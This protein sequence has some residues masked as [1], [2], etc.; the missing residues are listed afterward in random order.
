MKLPKSF[1]KHCLALILSLS[2]SFEGLALSVGQ[3][4]VTRST[5]PFFMLDS[6]KPNVDGPR[7]AHVGIKIR[8]TSGGQLNQVYVKLT[9]LTKTGTASASLG[10]IGTS[11]SIQWIGKMNSTDTGI[12]YFYI[13]F[14]GNTAF[15]DTVKLTVQVY[16]SVSGTVS[17]QTS[18]ILRSSISSNAGGLLVAKTISTLRHIGT[19]VTDTVTYSY[20][21]VQ[22]G[23]E[24]TLYPCGDTTFK[25]GSFQLINALVLSSA[26]ASVTAGTRNTLYFVATATTGGSG[27][28]I[29]MVYYYINKMVSGDSTITAPYA[30][31]T[32]GNTNFKY[33]SNFRAAG[34]FSYFLSATGSLSVTK[35]V[36]SIHNYPG[37]TVTY[38]V[39]VTNNNGGAVT[40]DYFQDTLPTGYTYVALESTSDITSAISSELPSAGNSGAISFRGG[41]P[42]TFPYVSYTVNASSTVSLKYKVK[43]KNTASL[44]SDRNVA[45]IFLGTTSGGSD[46][47][48]AYVH[49]HVSGTLF[50]DTNGLTDALVNGTARDSAGSSLVYAYLVNGSNQVMQRR[51][52]NNGNGTFTFDSVPAQTNYTVRLSNTAATINQT[53]PSTANLPS[54]YVAIGEDYGSANGAGSGNESGTP[55]ASIA[56]NV[57]TAHLTTIQFGIQQAPTP[58]DTT[59]SSQL[60]PGGTNAITIATSNF[61]GSDP[62]GRLI[63]YKF[64]G[65][66]SNTTTFSINGTSYTSGTFPGAG[67]TVSSISSVTLDPVDGAL[68]AVIP[69][70]V[71]DNAGQSGLSTANVNVPLQLLSVSGTLFND[72]NGLVDATVS[73]TAIDQASS[74]TIYAYL[75]NG[76]GDVVAKDTLNSGNGT[77]TFSNAA[78]GST[79]YTVRMSTSNV[80]VG[81][82]AP[83]SASLPNGWVAVGDSYGSS[84]IAGSGNDSSA[85]GQIEVT[86]GTANVTGVNFG[87]E[88]SNTSY[89]KTYTNQNPNTIYSNSGNG[90]YPK[91]LALNNASGTS[92]TTVNASSA[93]ILP[94]KVSASDP[95][96]GNYGGSSGSN[97]VRTF[98]LTSLPDAS[99]DVL[100]YFNGSETILLIEDPTDT[101]SSWAYWDETNEQYRIPSF[102][103]SELYVYS[104]NNGHASFSFHYGYLDLAG[105]LGTTG[106]YSVVGFGPLSLQ[107]MSF[108]S[109]TKGNKTTLKWTTT[110][111]LGLDRYVLEK[112]MDLVGWTNVNEQQALNKGSITNIYTFDDIISDGNNYYRLRSMEEN[113][114]S[115]LSKI[116][117]VVGSHAV[118]ISVYPV[119]AITTLN[120]LVGETSTARVYDATGKM[121]LNAGLVFKGKPNSLNV[122]QLPAGFYSLEL[123][124]TGT[125][126]IHPIEVGYK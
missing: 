11:D 64:T 107:L 44:A 27:N 89:D 66:P 92:N 52:L 8:N 35:S 108:E 80:N 49:V 95:E 84:N 126:S 10:Y 21:N 119:P 104:I 53:A 36:S 14:P 90:T 57:G 12:A 48:L 122:E 28:Q 31:L 45:H 38:T 97:S 50:R 71:I 110:N 76:S 4:A 86:T 123:T 87:I 91:K 118:A 37:D 55:D 101:D 26:V 20:G 15:N 16:D 47:A 13:K 9:A 109:K 17:F 41:L 61:T 112:S 59:L 5:A 56:A 19:L 103:A 114:T 29:K 2:L 40:F 111:E 58:T 120:I 33:S 32:S 85:N 99:N 1:I 105:L 83:S 106:I 69:F 25:A 115:E 96:D 68:T 100:V 30:G 78:Y 62:D 3:V 75:V 43:L 23:D 116:I 54:T 82:S 63:Q 18:M 22:T 73:G 98:V 67:V 77:Y 46:T 124:T 6:N 24:L 74:T 72:A 7:A 42:G 121:V 88:R 113:G 70:N 102:D 65:F 81:A 79:N 60:N 39:A 34:F 94:G 117:S 93:E 51:T 125:R